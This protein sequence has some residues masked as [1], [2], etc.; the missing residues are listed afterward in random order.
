M[1][2]P[3]RIL[4]TEEGGADLHVVRGTVTNS[5][6]DDILIGFDDP[7]VKPV[8]ANLITSMSDFSIGFV[9]TI[10][11]LA[12]TGITLTNNLNIS[13]KSSSE[14]NAAGLKV[15][16]TNLQYFSFTILITLTKNPGLDLSMLFLRI[17]VHNK[18]SDIWL[19]PS[20][21]NIPK[22]ETFKKINSTVIE[23]MPLYRLSVFAKYDDGMVCDVS[24]LK[25]ISPESGGSEVNA[26]SWKSD[27]SS[28][29]SVNV[30]GRLD[31]K[32]LTSG[33]K[34]TLKS[35][36]LLGGGS[37]NAI[38]N[39]VRPWGDL[40]PGTDPDTTTNVLFLSDGFN[41]SD[42]DL[43][44][45]ENLVCD[46]VSKLRT[47][48]PS[49]Y[50]H[51][52]DSINYW[53]CFL[54]SRERG[55][56]IGYD[57][58]MFRKGSFLVGKEIEASALYNPLI[59]RS[60]DDIKGLI[61]N[62]GL[63]FPKD[64]TMD[65]GILRD[66]ILTTAG[67]VGLNLPIN[68]NAFI[69]WLYLSENHQITEEIDSLFGLRIGGR[70]RMTPVPGR[71]IKLHPFRAQRE[72]ID[73]FLS[74][75]SSNGQSVAKHWMDNF[76][77]SVSFKDHVRG[78]DREKVIILSKGGVY[79][80][81]NH[82]N[83]AA[84]SCHGGNKIFLEKLPDG[85]IKLK[86]KLI[87][88]DKHGKVKVTVKF[89]YLVSHELSHSFNLMDEYGGDMGGPFTG[90]DNNIKHANNNNDVPNLQSGK[91]LESSP[92][93]NLVSLNGDLIKWRWPRL[94]AAGVLTE[95]PLAFDNSTANRKFII[96]LKSGHVNDFKQASILNPNLIVYLRK[97]NHLKFTVKQYEV[98]AP[99]DIIDIDLMVGTITVEQNNTD[100]KLIPTDFPDGSVLVAPVQIN[101]TSV[102]VHTEF[103]ELISKDVREHISDSRGPLNAPR[104]KKSNNK[105]RRKCPESS[106][107]ENRQWPF[108]L[109]NNIR[110]RLG[111]KRAKTKIIGVY[112]GGAGFDCG[113]YHPS[114]WC[115]LRTPIVKIKVSDF[116]HVCK[117]H[118]VD[119]IDPSKHADIDKEYKADYP[120]EK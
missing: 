14:V 105:A 90:D 38:I 110:K 37:A 52:K 65:D 101:P 114:G 102:M 61:T 34:V 30:K 67:G 91:S 29:V 26:F 95:K 116:C 5:I 84:L 15:V 24:L 25:S 28:K 108:N 88:R 35:S 6:L 82:D 56:T 48:G 8:S 60:Y 89:H 94:Q 99:L 53:M 118:L 36:S 9:S 111:K 19:T 62:C 51:L 115:N 1:A 18:V 45:F 87:K 112:E 107:D 75:R 39:V 80:G 68:S 40:N 11:G 63:P 13:A 44:E 77:D 33:I 85:K 104:G 113:I 42:N 32:E 7:N 23:P 31:G 100:P 86:P 120:D 92:E 117:Y 50:N 54:P 79:S 64:V 71:K 97:R 17:Y 103:F 16:A 70:P 43:R 58:G 10:H 27:D 47:D 57:M 74:S 93:L 106:A 3:N 20:E 41:D 119:A 109:P 21:L 69:T 59:Q 78:K 81:W 12:G 49:P 76:D 4:W 55:A 83:Y 46:V 66:R 2:T 72:H 22:T 73:R 96:K 98:A